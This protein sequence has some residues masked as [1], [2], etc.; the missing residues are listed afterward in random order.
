MTRKEERVTK[1]HSQGIA[2]EKYG[3]KDISTDFSEV[4]PVPKKETT[5]NRG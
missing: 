4:A 5:V 2:M 1:A 3:G